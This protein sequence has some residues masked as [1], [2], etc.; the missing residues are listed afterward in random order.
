MINVLKYFRFVV[1][2]VLVLAAGLSKASAEP[3]ETII[4]N[5]PSQ[6]RIDLVV[7]GDG[8]TAGEAQKYR[9]D[10]LT[11]VQGFFAQE[12]FRE[13]QTY[14][15]VQRIDVFS[16]QSGADHPERSEFVDTAFDAAYNCN[17]IQRLIC[18]NG[19]K[20]MN[21]LQNSLAPNQTDLVLV[22]VNDSEYGGSGGPAVSSMH[23]A[24]IEIVLHEIGHSFGVLADEYGGPGP[25]NCVVSEFGN[26]NVTKE[27]QRALIKWGKWIDPST[28]IPTTSFLPGVPG[29]YEGAGYCDKGLYRPTFSSKMRSLGSPFE[30]IN[31][32][33]LIK[34]IYVRLSPLESSLPAPSA[35]SLPVGATQYFSATIPTPLTHSLNISWSVDGQTVANG[36]AYTFDAASVSAGTHSVAVTVVDPTP[37]V[38][39]DPNQLLRAQRTWTVTIGAAVPSLQLSATT[40]SQTEG[41]VS[42]DVTVT[43]TGDAS[44]VAT[45][46]YRT[47]DDFVSLG[48]NPDC[49]TANGIALARCDYLLI[50]GTLTF[51][52]GETSKTISVPVVDDA[53]PE[54]IEHFVISVSSPKGALLGSMT[55]AVVYINDNETAVGPNPNDDART[56]VRQHYIDF[57]NR[58]PDAAGWDFWTHEITSCGS[59]PQCIEVKR[60][61]VSASFFLSIE[62]RDTGYFVYRTYKAAYGSIGMP[63]PLRL[64]EFMPDTQQIGRGIQVGIGNW[65]QQLE[66]NKQTYLLE[67]VQRTRF[68]SD[69]PTT[70]TPAEFVDKLLLNAGL[71]IA[72]DERNSLVSEFGGAGNTA[73]TSARVRVLRRIVENQFLIQ[74]ELN[75]A[76]VLMEYYGYLR[77]NPYD[78]PEQTLDF[79]GYNFWLT[80]LNQFGGN[81]VEA[82]MVKAFLT[83]IE[84]R[85]RFGPN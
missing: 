10:A 43:R 46:D 12:P 9:N 74:Q 5:G 49:S 70:R 3:Y 54:G 29:L 32:E 2:L 76:F 56:F 48:A 14:F 30:Q 34:S 85:R 23:P 61:N 45:I 38:R 66:S 22:I 13:Y 52:A 19:T 21:V 72:P 17:N 40:Y 71:G 65:E 8:Y 25:P 1:P 7:V 64:S 55:S 68:T 31:S 11:V 36:L 6:N 84:Y 28:P 73:D 4:N 51:A 77:R 81:Y 67:F 27:T 20:L 41:N 82:E 53:Y 35:I 42:V 69:H 24:A 59:N 79:T 80:K 26:A 58:E 39:N 33:Q 16:N 78:P 60:I 62:F 50:S 44:G 47:S 75:R 18:V 15:N 83:S 57:L 63:V 37:Q